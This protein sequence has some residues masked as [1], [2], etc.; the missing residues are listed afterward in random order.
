MA[1]EGHARRS[2]DLIYDVE[3]EIGFM[4]QVAATEA[5]RRRLGQIGRALLRSVLVG[6]VQDGVPLERRREAIIQELA[7]LALRTQEPGPVMQKIREFVKDDI[8]AAIAGPAGEV[9][10]ILLAEPLEE[11]LANIVNDAAG[12]FE[13]IPAEAMRLDAAIRRTLVRITQDGAGPPAVLVTVPRLR[14]ALAELLRGL[15][16]RLPVLAFTELPQD[17]I[18]VTGGLV[19]VA[20]EPVTP[21]DDATVTGPDDAFRRFRTTSDV[22]SWEGCLDELVRA[23]RLDGAICVAVLLEWLARISGDL[24]AETRARRLLDDLRRQLCSSAGP[25]SSRRRL[26][27]V[28]LLVRDG[29]GAHAN[30]LLDELAA[31]SPG[32]VDAPEWLLLRHQDRDIATIVGLRDRIRGARPTMFV[33]AV[34]EYALALVHVGAV[35]EAGRL[36]DDGP[37][38]VDDPFLRE[39]RG[40]IG[41]RLGEWAAAWEAYSGSPWPAHRLRAAVVGTIAGQPERMA[42]VR[43]D[44]P[45]LRTL[46][47]LEGDLDQADVARSAAFL[48]ACLWR[49]IVSW[50]LELEMGK[51]SFR[52][53]QFAEAEIHYQRAQATAPK[54]AHRGIARLRFLALS[55]MT[56]NVAHAQLNLMPEALAAGFD[57]LGPDTAEDPEIRS[58]IAAETRDLSRI[59]PSLDAWAPYDRSVA[60]DVLGDE[61]RAVDAALE[62]LRTGYNPRAARMVLERLHTAGLTGAAAGL[63]EI[64]LVE[65]HGDF[66]GLWETAQTVQRLRPAAGEDQAADDLGRIAERFRTRLVEMSRFEFTNALRLHEL[67]RSA[68]FEDLAEELLLGAARQAESVSEL[69]AVAVLHRLSP[70]RNLHADQEGLRCLARAQRLARE[71]RERLEIARE[72]LVFG[73]LR[74]GRAILVQERVLHDDTVLSHSEMIAALQCA[75]GCTPAERTAL[76]TRAVQRL[77]ADV[78][79]GRVQ[80]YP[81][82][83]GERL[84]AEL[85]R[86]VPDQ[87]EALVRALDPRLWNESSRTAW[88]GDDESSWR[89]TETALRASVTGDAEPD[90]TWLAELPGSDS[91]GVRLLVVGHLRNELDRAQ[92]AARRAVPDL[93]AERTPIAKAVDNGDG[94][95]TIELCDLWRSRLTGDGRNTDELRRFFAAE[96]ELRQHWEEQHAEAGAAH[97]RRV[98]RLGGSCGPRSTPST[99]PT[100]RRSPTRRWARCSRPSGRTCRSWPRARRSGC[101][102]PGASWPDRRPRRS[103]NRS[104]RD[105]RGP[106][107]ASAALAA[108]GGGG[109]GGTPRPRP[110]R[111]GRQRRRPAAAPAPRGLRPRRA[112]RAPRAG[113]AGGRP[114]RTEPAGAARAGGR[115]SRRPARPGGRPPRRA[116]RHRRADRADRDRRRLRLARPGPDRSPHPLPR[117]RVVD[118]GPRAAAGPRGRPG[119]VRGGRAGRREPPRGARRRTGGAGVGR[120]HGRAP[121]ARRGAGDALPARGRGRARGPGRGCRAARRA[122]GRRRGGSRAVAWRGEDYLLVQMGQRS[123][124]RAAA[125]SVAQLRREHALVEGSL[126][127]ENER[128]AD[129]YSSRAATVRQTLRAGRIVADAR[130]GSV[131]AA[132]DLL[133]DALAQPGA[134]GPLLDQIAGR[135]GTAGDYW[136]LVPAVERVLRHPE[137]TAVPRRLAEQLDRR[138][139]ERLDAALALAPGPEEVFDPVPTPVVLEVSEAIVPIVDNRQDGGHFLFEL[140]PQVR[141]L[142]RDTTGVRVPGVRARGSTVLAPGEFGIQLDEAWVAHGR[143]LLDGDYVLRT[144]G[145]EAVAA[146]VDFTEIHPL[147]GDRGRWRIDPAPPHD[148]DGGDDRGGERLT[149]P[150][151]LAH[152][153]GLAV[154]AGLH[155]FLGRQELEPMMEQWRA[156]DADLVAR[157]LPDERAVLRLMVVLKDLVTDRV[158]ISDWRAVLGAVAAAG[159]TGAPVPDLRRAVRHR[160]RH[161]LPGPRSGPLL[162]PMP[163]HVQA[164]VGGT[165]SAEVMGQARHD[166]LRWLRATVAAAGPGI[167]VVVHETAT[168]ERVAVLARAERDVVTTFCDDEL[169]PDDGSER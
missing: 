76:A 151:Y 25:G 142:I 116:R 97:L 49:P 146:G 91:F 110:R 93:P 31:E 75:R 15:D 35:R 60:Y 71:R 24:E 96:Q 168:R 156:G 88:D 83:F 120:R 90:G 166:V 51:L 159:G 95:R 30:R 61:G 162:V 100:G 99:P 124:R 10:T 21:H 42:T 6:L 1:G 18:T 72:Y 115:R 41:E 138:L 73:A 77:N 55:W 14:P 44:T 80:P 167:S 112:D 40:S 66:L 39:V 62:S 103:W 136:A 147:T 98:V 64:V 131:V 28:P 45:V 84:T 26:C 107:R 7:D 94:P 33:P 140:I 43:L 153:V 29:Y 108:P 54:E 105:G 22:A 111:P 160:L 165:G 23:G 13:Q 114:R 86:A 69:V 155:M 8:C 163:D 47:E 143:M 63:A 127:A 132:A 102:R 135:V 154:R 113:P 133:R 118:R 81:M 27:W 117:H 87:C 32:L 56:D 126:G 4:R 17:L 82:T 106:R 78:A 109:G 158:P 123:V 70:V 12:R 59:P 128:R 9:T 157:V 141:D 145:T 19:D 53:R 169:L 148:D 37:W 164:A 46:V 122:V 101:G 79:A 152:R 121:V 74:E 149:R 119:R 38:D 16:H 11:E 5:G 34:Y 104:H 89:V 48:S 2:F 3:L 50:V 139:G 130:A 68:G 134:E 125:R 57:A 144:V 65:S 36:L 161:Q 129:T 20:A 92:D 67:F 137:V 85:D 52:R 150:Q 58:W